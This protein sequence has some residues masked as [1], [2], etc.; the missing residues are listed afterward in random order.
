MR[1]KRFPLKRVIIAGASG[2]ICSNLLKVLL[3]NES[4][5]EV[6]ALVRT[7]LPV[8]NPKLKQLITDFDSLKD[9]KTELYGEAIYCCLGSTK[10]R[11]P[12]KDAYRKVDHDYPLELANLSSENIHQF[13]L[14]SAIDANDRSRFFYNRLKGETERDLK[15]IS[16]SAIHIYQ[17]SLIVG[18][19]IE[20][21][22]F[23]GIM[24]QIM[25]IVDPLL[26]G[27][28]K[29]YQSIE[30]STVAQAMVNQTFKGIEGVH[31][32]PSH[33]IKQLA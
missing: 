32:Y 16:F 11:T 4:I 19:R 20:K 17:P 18:D 7:S 25:K 9:L 30:A 29:R 5:G 1:L 33:I 28:L 3:K 21:R 14:V 31:T 27:S 24:A 2:L 12:N 10:K 26:V 22:T 8:N 15:R 23:E 13:H 6:V